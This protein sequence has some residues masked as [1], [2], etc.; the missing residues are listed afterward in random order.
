MLRRM[1]LRIIQGVDRTFEVMDIMWKLPFL[2]VYICTVTTAYWLHWYK[3]NMIV[4]LGVCLKGM[5]VANNMQRSNRRM[6][7]IAS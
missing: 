2:R 7:K 4:F 1:W 3:L 6:E 5:L